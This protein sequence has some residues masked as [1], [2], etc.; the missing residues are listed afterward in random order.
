MVR[1][2]EHEL[3]EGRG[4]EI[5]EQVIEQS[6]GVV[7]DHTVM[8]D[9]DGFVNI[10]DFLDGI[11][12]TVIC[13]IEDCF[14]S[15]DPNAKCSPLSLKKGD[16]LLDGETAL[17]FV[18]SRHGRTDIDRARRQ[19]I[20]LS[21][22]KR[23]LTRTAIIPKLPRLW[24]KLNKHVSTDLDMAAALKIG[25]LVATSDK[26]ALHGLVLRAP[27]VTPATV[28]GGKQVLLLDEALAKTAVSKLFDAPLPGKK[29]QGAVCPAK[30][31]GLHWREARED[32]KTGANADTDSEPATGADT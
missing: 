12:I 15:R 10:I 6:L 23:R 28:A 25:L 19:Q 26:G 18:R 21:G 27:I 30:D 5:L 11:P 22:L 2:A 14:H 7:I 32:A 13:P 1:V 24:Q 3:G 16:H 20:V 29:R 9:F 4:V 31:V 17:K 8:A